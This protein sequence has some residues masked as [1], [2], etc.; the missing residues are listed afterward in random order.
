MNNI[1]FKKMIVTFLLVISHSYAEAQGNITGRVI[2]GLSQPMPFVNVVLLNRVDST[3][4]QGFVTKDDGTFTIPIDRNDGLLKVSSVGYQTRY[5]QVRQSNLGDIQMQF[6]NLKLGEV[7]VKASRPQF[8]MGDDCMTISVQNSLLRQAGTAD[9]VLSQLPQVSGRNGSFTVFG[10]GKPLIYIN[11]RKVINSS[12]LSQ[13]K[14]SD[15]KE[16][17]LITNPGAQYGGAVQAVIRIKTVRLQGDGWG[18]SLYNFCNFSRKFSP[19]ESLN[20]K[21][22]YNQLELFGNFRIQSLHNRQYSEYE[23]TML[24]DNVIH[25]AGRETIFNNGDKQVRGQVGFNYDISKDHSFGFTYGI[26]KS[27]H[28][29]VRSA[30]SLDFS[31]DKM[32]EGKIHMKSAFTSYHTPDHELDTYYT[33]KIGK[34]GIDFNGTYFH[35][36][37][38]RTQ[39]KEEY[40]NISGMQFIDIDNVTRN[41]MLAGKI[42]ITYPLLKGKLNF[43]SEYTDAQS[44]GCNIN[45][46]QVFDNTE[47]KIKE[48]NLAGFAEYAIPFG[49]FRARAGVRYEHVVSDYYS[50]GEWQD[51]PSRKY[52]DWFPNFSLSWSKGKLQAQLGYIAKTARPS[53]RNLSSWMQYDNCYEYQ[54]GNP[55]LRP[56]QIHSLELTATRSWLTFTAGYKNMKDQVAYVMKP[57]DGNIFIK[58]YANIDRIQNLYTS[59]TVSPKF[60]IYQPMYEV[61]ISKQFLDDD[62]YGEGFSLNRPLLLFRMNNRF[63]ICRDFTVSVNLSYRSSYA[64]MICV[65]KE[66][67][68]L[69]VNVYKSFFKSKLVCYLWGR[70]LLQTQKRRYTM[71]GINSMFTTKQ[72]MDSRCFSIGI[73]YNFNTTRSKYK[74]T[75]AGNAEKNRL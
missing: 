60:G 15:I 53:Y 70:D 3:F 11:N 31:I 28:D 8:K 12:E 24:G 62:V 41:Q 30:S 49:N 21:Y 72:D 73:Q 36:K 1:F 5:I 32:T 63:A 33:G 69:D 43:G 54:G 40:S 4:I 26:M 44:L 71:Y 18:L 19:M 17:E 48:R 55:L 45:A 2:D 39:D 57:Y 34:F 35:S 20:L 29:V 56:S 52:S 22:R 16:V 38:T 7:V 13:L 61:S 9:D 64:S 68:S 27:L 58:T 65:Y 37:Q 59:L 75:G 42:I 23:Q 10:K 67:G 74:G 47:T 66:E 51:E 6:D 14:S 50:K 46:Q 25:E